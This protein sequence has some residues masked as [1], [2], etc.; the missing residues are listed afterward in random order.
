MNE[1]IKLAYIQGALL[2]FE[3]AGMSKEAAYASCDLLV[4][5]AEMP[6]YSPEEEAER[7]ALIN[8]Y[9]PK[10]LPYGLLG[11]LGGG[12]GVLGG[13]AIGNRLNPLGPGMSGKP[14]LLGTLLGGAL[15]TGAGLLTARK[16]QGRF[17]Q[18]P[19]DNL[20]NLDRANIQLDNLEERMEEAIENYD[21]ASR[22]FK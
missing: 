19:L 6:N 2:A 13:L 9:E 20:R 14:A 10:T 16:R 7:Q 1:S 17:R 18:A 8:K 11:G 22:N 4:K 15:G 12:A 21:N 3:Q 5:A